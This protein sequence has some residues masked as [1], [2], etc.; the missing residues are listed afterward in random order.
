MTS[1]WTSEVLGKIASSDDL[2]IAPLRNDGSTY[3]TLT[4][5]WSVA[6]DSALYVRAYNG[7]QS[8]WY[9]SALRQRAGR[10]TVAG[11]TREVS[12]EPVEGP[13]LARIDEAYL[14]KYRTSEYLSP[15]IGQRTRSDRS[16]R[17]ARG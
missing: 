17:P 1:G 10:V 12:F 16:D 14:V 3:G 11:M 15:M 5:I 4:W 8:R 7:K 2:H 9:Q 13:I 6:V